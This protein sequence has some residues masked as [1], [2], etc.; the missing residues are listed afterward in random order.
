MKIEEQSVTIKNR[1]ILLKQSQEE[2]K[3]LKR[4]LE[5]VEQMVRMSS[6]PVMQRTLEENSN[7]RI[8]SLPSLV[9]KAEQPIV[10]RDL[11]PVGTGE[12]RDLSFLGQMNRTFPGMKNLSFPVEEL[13]EQSL[14]SDKTLRSKLF[15]KQVNPK[16]K[17]TKNH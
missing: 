14:R 7:Q 16:A 3:K 8:S 6:N 11:K 5:S 13:M 12:S 2:M 10:S 17:S 1:G 4:R 9:K 15:L